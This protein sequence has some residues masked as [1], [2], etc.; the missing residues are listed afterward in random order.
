MNRMVLLRALGVVCL[1]ASAPPALAH[2][3]EVH[4]APH[5]GVMVTDGAMHFELVADPK[6]GLKIYFSSADGNPLPASAA[7]EV[8]VE[9]EHPKART[10]Y[11]AMSID[12]TGGF[13]RG[14]SQ[15]L[16]DKG[17]V[18]HIG[19]VS[20]GRG[21]LKDVPASQVIAAMNNAGHHGH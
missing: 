20:Q 18:L 3:D 5:G 17:A 2:G 13:W 4:T 21:A 8:A 10:E 19:V 14:N 11:V 16:T 15:P 9:I 12:R 7:S 1:F 6:G